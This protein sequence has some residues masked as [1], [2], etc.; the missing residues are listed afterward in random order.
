[1]K[2]VRA[3]V[4]K[5]RCS[6]VVEQVRMTREAVVISKRGRPVAELAP[7]GIREKDIFGRLRGLMKIV[8]DIESPVVS[9]DN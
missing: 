7:V 6:K 4:F 3:G 8:G 9:P 5:A 1:M 2:R